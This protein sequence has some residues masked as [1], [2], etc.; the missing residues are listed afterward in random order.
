MERRLDHK[1]R[2]RNVNIAFRVSPEEEV[3]IRTAAKLAG[4]TR[5]EYVIQRV[6]NGNVL[7]QGNPKVFKAL[8]DQLTATL[9]ELHRLDSGSEVSEELTD[10]IRLIAAIMAG[11]K[12][13]ES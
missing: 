2:W 8:R 9:A 6:L 3:K 12:E 13:D 10:T 4:L 5:Q 11:M 7:V 1:G